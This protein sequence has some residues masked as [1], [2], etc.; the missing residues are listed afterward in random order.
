MLILADTWYPGWVATVDGQPAP[1]Y[2]PYGAL[3]GVVVAAGPH[4]IEFRYRPATAWLG[5]SCSML[6]ILGAC[7]MSV[8]FGR[9][10]S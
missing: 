8:L 5:A 9:A 7:V 1:I 10:A 2:Q 3:R 6:G 4:H